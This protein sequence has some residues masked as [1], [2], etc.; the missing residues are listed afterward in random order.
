VK[1]KQILKHYLCYATANDNRT[2]M[3]DIKNL[4]NLCKHKHGVDSLYLYIAISKVNEISMFDKVFANTVRSMFADCE[5][6]DLVEIFF[7]DNIGRDF[8]SYS[9]MNKKIQQIASKDDLVFF[10]NR[11]A[12]GPFKDDWYS[13]YVKQF[14]LHEKIALVGSTINFN[15]H[16]ERSYRTNLPHIQTYA[17]L[18]QVKF[19]KMLKDSFPGEKETERL[20]IITHGEIGLSQ[21]FLNKGYFINCLE[22]PDELV[23]SNSKKLALSDCKDSVNQDHPFYHRRYMRKNK[24][25]RIK[26]SLVESLVFYFPYIFRR[27]HVSVIND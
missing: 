23:D 27:Y 15:D 25:R 10:K 13:L 20:N 7:K 1:D 9:L 11:S 8:S 22:W 24:K 26:D 4:V 2:Y 18:T 3:Q 21:F 12:C 17:F 6:I 5:T 19:L 14:A 16:P